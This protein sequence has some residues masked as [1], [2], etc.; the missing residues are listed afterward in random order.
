MAGISIRGL[1]KSYGGGAAMAA[2]SDLALDIADGQFV[3][4]LGPSGCGKTTTLRL[5][6][7]F[8]APDAGTI[9]ADGRLVSSVRLVPSTSTSIVRPT[10]RWARSAA[11]RCTASTR[12]SIRSALSGNSM[13]ASTVMCG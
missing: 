13:F 3:T 2:V 11:R 1:S 5:I 7:G 12:R 9:H 10:K 8:I 6:A 4:L